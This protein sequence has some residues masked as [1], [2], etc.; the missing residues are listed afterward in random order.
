MAAVSRGLYFRHSDNLNIKGAK[1]RLFCLHP[2]SALKPAIK[3]P[4][5]QDNHLS[6]VTKCRGG[7][8]HL[9][10]SLGA[11]PARR[12]GTRRICAHTRYVLL[13]KTNGMHNRTTT[14][15]D[16]HA[17]RIRDQGTQAMRST[18]PTT[19]CTTVQHN[20]RLQHPCSHSHRNVMEP[21]VAP[22]PC[23]V[24]SRTASECP[25]CPNSTAL[26]RQQM[27]EPAG[28]LLLRRT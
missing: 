14:T 27:P 28:E 15:L 19:H 25:G 1:Q 5:H 17:Q 22:T 12:I 11:P 24:V 8:A 20:D 16:W 13:H 18:V 6:T 23:R 3:P 10:E 4:F 9:L 7:I 2:R 26:S 21:R